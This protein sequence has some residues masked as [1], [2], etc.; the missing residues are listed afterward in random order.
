[1]N[2]LIYDL[3]RKNNNF[4]TFI[5]INQTHINNLNDVKQKKEINLIK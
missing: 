5:T 1:M 4:K 2:C 3:I